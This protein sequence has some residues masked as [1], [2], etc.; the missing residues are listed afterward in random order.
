MKKLMCLGGPLDGQFVNAPNVSDVVIVPLMN[1]LVWMR[2][3]HLDCPGALPDAVVPMEEGVYQR[4]ELM[5]QGDGYKTRVEVMAYFG[6]A[7]QDRPNKW[8]FYR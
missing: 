2:P 4:R 3:A 7:A 6:R 1:K 5:F 8:R